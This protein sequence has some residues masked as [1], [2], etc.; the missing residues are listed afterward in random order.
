MLRQSNPH[1]PNAD[2][3]G[4]IHPQ[5]DDRRSACR[6]QANNQRSVIAPGEVFD[7]KLQFEDGTTAC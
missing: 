3:R 7:P 1:S 4:S 2:Y 6:G 5:S